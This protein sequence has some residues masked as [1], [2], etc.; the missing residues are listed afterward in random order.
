MQ[1]ETSCGLKLKHGVAHTL[2][3]ELALKVGVN[4]TVKLAHEE[5]HE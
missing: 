5:M 4:V 3:A 2:M 1:A